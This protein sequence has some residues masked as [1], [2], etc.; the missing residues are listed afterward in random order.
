MNREQLNKIIKNIKDVKIG[1]IGDFCL[2]VYW[3]INMENSEISVETGLPTYPIDEHEYSLGG[4]GNVAANLV[5]LGIKKVHVFGVLG[6]DMFASRMID[7]FDTSGIDHDGIMIQD[8]NWSTNTYI[9]PIKGKNEVNR[10]DFGNFNKLN[11]DVGVKV[12]EKL[13]ETLPE[14]DAIIINQQVQSGIHTTQFRSD[15]REF[16]LKNSDKIFFVDSRSY[17]DDYDGAIRKMNDIEALALCNMA[18]N[19]ESEN[20]KQ[21]VIKAASKLTKK[22]EKPVVVTAGADGCIIAKDDQ[23]FEVKS[24]KAKGEIDTVGA[25]D[26]FL[27]GISSVLATDNNAF[28]DAGYFGNLVAGVTIKKLLQCGTATPA[29]I[30]DLFNNKQL[31]I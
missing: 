7:L 29:E 17:G 27:S 21:E 5:A 30:I 10:F 4:A 2:D 22:Y 15:L 23:V 14:L 16:V 11:N 26:S 9:K 13:Q 20:Y 3:N 25:G 1:I 6:K 8:A 28:E 19:S 18:A 24:P 12:L 31:T